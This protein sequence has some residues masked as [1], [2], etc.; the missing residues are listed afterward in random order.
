MERAAVDPSGVYRG[1]M[2][3][4]QLQPLR[5]IW[6]VVGDCRTTAL[7]S[8][9]QCYYSRAEGTSTSDNT[10]H[11]RWASTYQPHILQ[12]I[13]Y[14][15]SRFSFQAFSQTTE[16]GRNNNQVDI[17]SINQTCLHQPVSGL[18][19]FYHQRNRIWSRTLAAERSTSC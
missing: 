17:R 10:F 12:R 6:Q 4:G 9:P 19:H 14:A 18:A 8:A 7:A 5:R 3:D 13:P 2:N 11:K 15:H 1:P 16:T